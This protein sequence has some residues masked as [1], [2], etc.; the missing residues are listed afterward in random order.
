MTGAQWKSKELKTLQD[1]LNSC[2]AVDRRRLGRRLARLDAE[3]GERLRALQSEVGLALQRKSEK[4]AQ[5]PRISYPPDL[6]ITSKLEA[7][8]AAIRDHPVTVVC[9]ETGSGK[10][11]QLP[12]L[13]LQLGYG[14]DAMIG[15]TQPRRIAART[16]ADRIAAETGMSRGQGVGFKIRH[17]DQTSPLT[18]VKI[19][20]DGVLLAEIR[21]DRWLNAYEVLI[22]DEAHERSLN[23]DFLLGY[24]KL[25]S[26]K[27][28][29]LRIV[30][31]SATIDVER[32]SRY[33]ANA[34]VIEVSGRGYPVDIRYQPLAAQDEE[35]EVERGDALLEAVTALGRESQGDIL[36]FLDGEREIRDMQK[37]LEKQQLPDTEVLPLYARLSNRLQARIFK[38]HRRR[39]IILATNVAETSLTIDG[40]KY[41]IDFGLAR[42]SRYSYRSKVQR[43]PIEKISKASANQ[44]AGR[45]GRTSDGICIRLYA[46]ED[47]EQ[48]PLFTDPEILRTSL[49]AVILQMQALKLGDILEFDFIDPPDKRYINDGI[50]LLLELGA[51]DEGRRLTRTG[52]LMAALP[53]DPRLARMLVAA[54][55]WHCLAE[56]LVIVSALA[57]QDPRERPL[58]A[59]EKA[60]QAH[61]KFA[62]EDS[63]FMWFVNFRKFYRARAAKLSRKQ[64]QKLCTQNFVSAVRVLEWQ[65]IH[66]QLARI[67]RDLG[68]KI[69]ADAAAYNNIHCAILSGL[70]SHVAQ[71]TDRHAYTGARNLRCNI[72]PGSGQFQKMPKWIMACELVE[73]SKLFARMVAKIDPAW[74]LKTASHL[75]QR[76]YSEPAWDDKTGQ[77]RAREKISLYGLVIE[78]GKS[79]PYAKVNPVEC[80]QM[81]I[82]RALVEQG[83]H[84]R[85]GYYRHNREL[86]ESI[87]QLEIKQRRQDILDEDAIYQFYDSRLPAQVCGVDSLDSWRREAEQ[88][89]SRILYL[90]KEQIML[91]A[92]ERVDESSYPD[93]LLVN[94]VKLPLSYHFMPGQDDDGISIDVP[95]YALN[96]LT[97]TLVERLVPGLLHEKIAALLK[98]LPRRQRKQLVPVPDTA[99]VCMEELKTRQGPLQDCLSAILF[100]RYGLEISANDWDSDSLPGHLQMN[101]RIIDEQGQCL[102]QGRDLE[103]LKARFSEQAT[104]H[105]LETEQHAFCR[106]GLCDWDFDELPVTVDIEINGKQLPAFPALV[107]DGESVSLQV[108]DTRARAA[109]ETFAGLRRLLLLRLARDVKYLKKNLPHLQQTV[110]LYAAIGDAAGLTD[111][112][113]NLVFDRVFIMDRQPPRTREAFEHLLEAQQ[114][115]LIPEANQIA[116]LVHEILDKYREIRA[117][118]DNSRTGM[119]TAAMVDI[120]SHLDRLV[121]DGFLRE[122][123][124][125]WLQQYPR[126]LAAL[127]RRIEKYDSSG[128]RHGQRI[129]EIQHFEEIYRGLSSGNSHRDKGSDD[130]EQLRWMIEEYR[131]SS[132]A[133]DLKTLIPVSRKRLEK[134][135]DKIKR[136]EP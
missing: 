114:K 59:Q 102:A 136:G 55:H 69:N 124:V 95:V 15:H 34:P 91:H 118:L 35:D 18:W 33:F 40:I 48:R 135:L 113:I 126:Y 68:M 110:L 16:I 105:Y 21:K 111:D 92:A 119:A 13:C 62:H 106:R 19:M 60:D 117:R 31:T 57:I 81:F 77:I 36:V 43:L 122:T 22:I 4:S 24:L 42:I 108:F 38:P 120:S 116:Q 32:F 61:A 83:L 76:E 99:A 44:R 66:D 132:F 78:A 74:L 87:R 28:P 84:S 101:V 7:L 9:G 134:L 11:T 82:R 112:L 63:D 100:A 127:L 75:V 8:G 52:R 79:V 25:L 30:V 20:T 73:T 85:A 107:D 23:I 129:Q 26:A 123:P 89:D 14:L 12:K 70:S 41:V 5:R 47:F 128:V 97:E 53:L 6:P 71:K 104:G 46:A 10:S 54:A 94:R 88:R 39:H 49:A 98:S 45:C 115:E 27:R 131:V 17:T 90:D 1:E 58:D 121:Y 80:R 65:D 64:L 3:D 103:Q 109:R 56:V 72:F 51:L 2:L 125:K 50:R 86:V 133:Q 130:V 96:M 67:C 29:E 37:F 93:E